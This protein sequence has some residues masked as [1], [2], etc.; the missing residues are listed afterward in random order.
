VYVAGMMYRR[1]VG[2]NTQE[3]RICENSVRQRETL[4]KTAYPPSPS[5]SLSLAELVNFRP[6]VR[7][8]NRAAYVPRESGQRDLGR[9]ADADK[10]TRES[11]PAQAAVSARVRRPREPFR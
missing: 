3:A 7:V 9:R 11:T 1:L 4:L 10:G 2:N 8:R 5:P 6:E